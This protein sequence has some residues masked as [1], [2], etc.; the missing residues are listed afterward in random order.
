LLREGVIERIAPISSAVASTRSRR[1]TGGSER[2]DHLLAA[3]RA[4][5]LTHGYQH[6][7]VDSLSRACGVSKETIYRYF[8][9][10]AALFRAAVEP[11][12]NVLAPQLQ[13]LDPQA[14]LRDV[15]ARWVR[16]I[17]DASVDAD[18][19]SFLWITIAV[20]RDFPDLAA[21]LSAHGLAG[22]EPVRAYLEARV[23]RK[24]RRPIPLELAGQ[25]GGLAVEGPRYLMG[26]PAMAPAERA[27]AACRTVDLFLQGCLTPGPQPDLGEMEVRPAPAPRAFDPHLEALLGEARRQFFARGYRGANLDEIGAA[28]RVGRGTLY[29]HFGSKAG[30]F[31]AAMLQAADELALQI[32]L[33]RAGGDLPTRLAHAGAVAAQALCSRAAIQLYRT[34]IGEARRA[35]DLAREVYLRT[36]AGI[37]EPVADWLRATAALGAAQI[38][39]P[40]WAAM[41]FATLVTGGNRHLTSDLALDGEGLQAQVQ[42]GLDLFLYGL[43]G[44]EASAR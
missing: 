39:D 20:A 6:L 18:G 8:P 32:R 1:P 25:L 7:S 30:L 11:R 17:H 35:P 26:W 19:T 14:P 21:D 16:A 5:F 2:I 9:D 24:D 22:L 38:D 13:G 44:R 37:V 15:L 40:D 33:E 31:E 41:Q 28:A 42:A 29:R 3:A 36:R 12:R 4:E 43:D 23:P 34:V 27:A 10:K